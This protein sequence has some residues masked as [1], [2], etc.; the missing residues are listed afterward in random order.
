[1]N[2]DIRIIIRAITEQAQREIDKVNKNLENID[3]NGKKA[4]EDLKQAFSEIG[5]KAAIAVA[6]VTAMVTALSQ[7]AR[8]SAE[9]QRSYGRLVSAFANVG[10]SADQAQATFSG[11][12]RFLGDVD[13][14]TEASS[15]LAQLT[16]DTENLAQWQTILQG[17]YATF[18]DS[19]PVE[20]LAEAAN[21]TAKVG[22]VTGALADALNWAGVSEEAFNAQLATLNMN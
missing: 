16:T 19:I 1:M 8:T 13:T 15:L 17:V 7:L 14:A 9:A 20:S 21:E 6:G 12:F 3:K 4:S 22:Q 11:L 5:K 2:E 10:L 18:P